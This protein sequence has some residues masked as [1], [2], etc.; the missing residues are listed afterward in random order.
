MRLWEVR[1]KV[2]LGGAFINDPQ[3]ICVLLFR[4]GVS[5]FTKL[6]IPSDCKSHFTQACGGLSLPVMMTGR[7]SSRLT[8]SSGSAWG[9]GSTQHNAKS[10]DNWSPAWNYTPEPGCFKVQPGDPLKNNLNPC[11]CLT[12]CSLHSSLMPL[13]PLTI[14]VWFSTITLGLK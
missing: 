4:K 10:E 12:L 6:H 8:I 13:S 11:T 9:Q 5:S 2:G 3:C 7:R 14:T 1:V